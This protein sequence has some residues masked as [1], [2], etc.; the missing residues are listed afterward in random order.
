M[1]FIF[2]KFAYLV[3]G[4]GYLSVLLGYIPWLTT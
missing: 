3:P 2:Y 4:P 1:G